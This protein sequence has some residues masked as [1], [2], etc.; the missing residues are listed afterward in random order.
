MADP[1]DGQGLTRWQDS[2]A[3]LVSSLMPLSPETMVRGQYE[4]YLDVEGVAP[5][6]ATETFIAVNDLLKDLP[7]RSRR[8]FSGEMRA[9]GSPEARDRARL[10]G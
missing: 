5:R 10:S 2:K 6:S 3:R 4:G 8:H 9:L 7:A 1:P